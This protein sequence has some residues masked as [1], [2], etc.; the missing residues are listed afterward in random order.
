M[1]APVKGGFLIRG[2]LVQQIE[3]RPEQGAGDEFPVNRVAVFLVEQLHHEFADVRGTLFGR[4][5]R[6][7]RLSRRRGFRHRGFCLIVA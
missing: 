7:G 2:Q 5:R 3:A 4:G 6:G 1:D